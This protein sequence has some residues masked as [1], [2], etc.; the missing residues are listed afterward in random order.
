MKKKTGKPEK[1]NELRK[2]AEKKLKSQKG[3]KNEILG[4]NAR[5]LIHELEVHQIELEM[6]N[7]E[8]RR[9][10]LELEKS[11]NKYYDLYDF[12]PVGYFLLDQKGRILEVNLKGSDLL[13][14]ERGSLI[15]KRFTQF[16]VPA[17]QDSFY[18][19]QKKVFKTKAI[20][21]LELQ[22]KNKDRT[23]FT[24]QLEGIATQDGEGN[25]T[26][27]RIVVIDITQKKQA[28]DDLVKKSYDLNERVKELSCLY[29]ISKLVEEHDQSLETILQGIV[30][31]IPPAWQYPEITCS[32]IIFNEQVYQTDNWKETRWKQTQDIKAYGNRVGVLEVIYLEKRTET[33]EGPFLKE[34]R[35][36]TNAIAERL[37]RIIERKRAQ[38]DLQKAHDELEQKVEER[39]TELTEANKLLESLSSQLLTAHEEERKLIA[40]DLH[41]SVGQALTVVKYHVEGAIGQLRQKTTENPLQTLDKLV[42]LIQ[43]SV[44]EMNR[45]SRH[46]RPSMLDDL[47]IIA[48]VSW[49]CREF[50]ETYSYLQIKQKIAVKEDD[51]PENLKIVIYRILQEGLNN[52]AKHS[53][54]NLVSIALKKRDTILEF[55]VKDNGRGF[56]A[57][58]T[59]SLKNG[60][61]R[62]GLLSMIKRAE[63]SGGSLKIKSDK[64]NGTTIQASWPY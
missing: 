27:T 39:T 13:G 47:G 8:L 38:E 51:I 33:D 52:V 60:E 44:I 16:I 14:L 25:F 36:L 2:R 6:Q 43:R 61:S 63:L 11:R 31:I 15:K 20:Q 26:H 49:F 21:T 45:V 46:L 54:A 37:G 35:D 12:A 5:E 28:Q 18:L 62:L 10:Q 41:D 57:E 3:I 42:P 32:R 24:S 59:L 64:E 34:E 17:F 22:L 48:T 23:T 50:Q 29:N 30:E 53:K 55:S 19:F 7:E 4:S 1:A 56:D 58:S 9:T 40:D